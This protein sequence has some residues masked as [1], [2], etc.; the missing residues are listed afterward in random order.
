MELRTYPEDHPSCGLGA[1]HF[2]NSSWTHGPEFLWK[3]E[4]QWSSSDQKDI[5]DINQLSDNDPDVK[6]ATAVGSSAVQMK[7]SLEDRLRSFSGWYRAKRAILL[8]F[9]FVNR[10]RRREKGLMIFKRQRQQ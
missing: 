3:D 6:R 5:Q 2:L 4:S 7:V 9:L 1:V 8:C 10:V